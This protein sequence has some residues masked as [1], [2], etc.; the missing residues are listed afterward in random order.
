MS[1]QICPIITRETISNYLLINRH[2]FLISFYQFFPTHLLFFFHINIPKTT[3]HTNINNEHITD[4]ISSDDIYKILM[5]LFSKHFYHASRIFFSS[6]FH[7]ILKIFSYEFSLEQLI[8]ITLFRKSV[9]N[10]ITN[11]ISK[12]F[13]D[14][15]IWFDIRIRE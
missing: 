12:T 13:L 14:H 7:Y 3:M 6:I 4:R 2:T 11:S 5:L 9:V 1:V 8:H 10:N 15:K